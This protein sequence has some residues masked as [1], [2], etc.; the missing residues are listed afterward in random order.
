MANTFTVNLSPDLA[1]ELIRDGV[2]GRSF[3]G[4][5]IDY[6]AIGDECSGR[7]MVMVFE[8][9]Y[10]RVGNRLTLTVTVDDLSGRTRVHAVGGGGG[11][12]LFGFDWGAADSFEQMVVSALAEYRF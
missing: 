5:L 9:H 1:T 8:K 7:C 6:H 12:G 3:T 4:E 10:S 2:E 11:E